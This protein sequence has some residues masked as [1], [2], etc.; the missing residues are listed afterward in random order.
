MIPQ[1]YKHGITVESVLNF[2]LHFNH[3]IEMTTKTRVR[4]SLLLVICINVNDNRDFL[5]LLQRMNTS[6]MT[7]LRFSILLLKFLRACNVFSVKNVESSFRASRVSLSF[8]SLVSKILFNLLDTTLPTPFSLELCTSIS[9]LLI[10]LLGT[11]IVSSAIL[12]DSTCIMCTLN[13]TCEQQTAITYIWTHTN[14]YCHQSHLECTTWITLRTIYRNIISSQMSTVGVLRTSGM[15][16]SLDAVGNS[17]VPVPVSA[18]CWSY[19]SQNRLDR[20]WRLPHL[21]PNIYGD[22][23]PE[24]KWPQREVDHSTLNKQQDQE[25]IYLFIYCIEVDPVTG[26]ETSSGPLLACLI[27]S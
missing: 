16:V 25:D 18:I 19:S 21:P 23:S 26:W 22:F 11:D 6:F 9:M 8:S 10:S 14:T 17:F 13:M 24:V 12:L 3:A 1:A 5:K 15:K 4:L 20:V 2:R 27:V 7:R